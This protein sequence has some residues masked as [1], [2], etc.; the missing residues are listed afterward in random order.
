MPTWDSYVGILDPLIFYS[1][2]YSDQQT[3]IAITYHDGSIYSV[4]KYMCLDSSSL[5]HELFIN[6]RARMRSEGLL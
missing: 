2:V 4:Y 3:S 1:H 6:P 5:A